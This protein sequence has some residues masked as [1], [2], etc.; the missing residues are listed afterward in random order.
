MTVMASNALISLPTE[1]RMLIW[2][3]AVAGEVEIDPSE[4]PGQTA[5]LPSNP[6]LPILLVCRQANLEVAGVQTALVARVHELDLTYW[7]RK[8]S[9]RYKRHLKLIR[10]RNNR[11]FAKPDM[12]RHI[13]ACQPS[14]QFA[15]AAL[16]RYWREV[17]IR[18]YSGWIFT[19]RTG[20]YGDHWLH[21]EMKIELS[22]AYTI[23]DEAG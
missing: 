9:L 1:V 17:S 2:S 13:V 5:S 12:R 10:V 19:E 6:A 14:D 16:E 8:T 3:Y 23:K 7:L 21:A 4:S 22:V 11:A 15:K 20:K 18:S